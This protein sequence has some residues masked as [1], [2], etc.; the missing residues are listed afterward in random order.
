MQYNLIHQT[1]DWENL[2]TLSSI[3]NGFIS[4]IT[5]ASHTLFIGVLSGVQI[6]RQRK[7]RTNLHSVLSWFFPGVICREMC[8]EG[9]YRMYTSEA[10]EYDINALNDSANVSFVHN[11]FWVSMRLW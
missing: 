9:E 4:A 10:M 3:R 1:A 11:I 6:V 2:Y 5:S 7:V 8:A